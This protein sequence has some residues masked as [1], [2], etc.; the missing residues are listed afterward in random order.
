MLIVNVSRLDTE[1]IFFSPNGTGLLRTL[2]VPQRFVLRIATEEI[3]HY[4]VFDT[5]EDGLKTC[6]RGTNFYVKG[7][8]EALGP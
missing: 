8:H 1:H 5:P 7:L 6:A 4:S 3:P 2:S